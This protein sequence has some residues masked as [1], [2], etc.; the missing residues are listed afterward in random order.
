MQTGEASTRL[1]PVGRVGVI[2]DGRRSPRAPDA[3][4][5]GDGGYL[6]G[7]TP[8]G[9][10]PAAAGAAVRGGGVEGAMTSIFWFVRT[11][12]TRY[13]GLLPENHSAVDRMHFCMAF[14]MVLGGVA[15]SLGF[16]VVSAFGA[17]FIYPTCVLAMVGGF[18]VW[19]QAR[20][21][22]GD[23]LTDHGDFGYLVAFAMS[24]TAVFSLLSIYR[25]FSPSTF[26]ASDAS[27]LIEDAILASTMIA[28]GTDVIRPIAQ[29]MTSAFVI[30][31]F[32]MLAYFFVK[33]RALFRKI[34]SRSIANY[35]REIFSRVYGT[36]KTFKVSFVILIY[37]W[38]IYVSFGEVYSL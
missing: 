24:F 18:A 31:E 38:Y 22:F 6:D 4:D 35:E 14:L 36:I 30:T 5:D 7:R 23:D 37:F 12:W 11:V 16:L 8:C 25:G 28:A 26:G 1:V 17:L 34:K 20:G 21:S 2:G 13:V 32:M 19:S 3:G 33:M 29:L 15:A 9:G 27:F 10:V